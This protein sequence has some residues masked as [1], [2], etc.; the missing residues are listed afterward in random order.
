MVNA[1]VLGMQRS[2]KKEVREERGEEQR[3]YESGI[4]RYAVKQ[5]Q[6]FAGVV[7]I[8]GHEEALRAEGE[9]EAGVRNGIVPLVQM[10]R[11][12]RQ[13]RYFRR[14]HIADRS[15]GIMTTGTGCRCRYC[16]VISAEK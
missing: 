1:E 6:C 3:V 7:D 14:Q 9:Q 15:R 12:D 11:W 16:S 5:R 2:L 8:G 13:H 10:P 4:E